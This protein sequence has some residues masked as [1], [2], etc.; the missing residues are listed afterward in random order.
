MPVEALAKGFDSWVP[1]SIDRY[2]ALES[3]AGLKITKQ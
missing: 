3:A 1:M 2:A